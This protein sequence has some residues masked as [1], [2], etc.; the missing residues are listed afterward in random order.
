MTAQDPTVT[1]LIVCS[2]ALPT[3]CTKQTPKSPEGEMNLEK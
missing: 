3:T 2:N 1:V